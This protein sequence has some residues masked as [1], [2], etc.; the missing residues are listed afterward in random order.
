MTCYVYLFIFR[1][2]NIDLPIVWQI[3]TK[4]INT[5]TIN[6]QSQGRISVD[7][8]NRIIFKKL[9]YA[10]ANIY[11]CWQRNELTGTV[12]LRVSYEL[13]SE[14]DK[15]DHRVLMLVSI[16]V[17]FTMLWVF[18]RAFQGRNRYTKH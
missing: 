14:I 13:T 18:W 7:F 1:N 6:Q 17:V 8:H 11:S 10:D 2:L 3:G 12:R 15:L 5:Q 9:R 4:K 16:P